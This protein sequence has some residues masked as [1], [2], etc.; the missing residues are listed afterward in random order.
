MSD[1]Q[2]ADVSQDNTEETSAADT[3][4]PEG[5]EESSETKEEESQPEGGESS[6]GE[7]EEAGDKP[8]EEGEA[9]G[10]KKEASE[11]IKYDL[12]MPKETLLNEGVV[13]E[14]VSMAKEQGLSNDQAQKFLDMQSDFLSEHNSLMEQ[15]HNEEVSSWGEQIKTDKELGG[16]NLGKNAELAKRVVSELVGDDFLHE[17]DESGYGNHP[18][19]FKLLVSVGKQMYADDLVLPGAQPN[20]PKSMADVFYPAT[21]ED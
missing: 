8:A 12:K 16:E 21:T 9:E 10:D 6:E 2:Q 17:L 15:K 13:D 3:L 4:Y 20:Q 18:K 7:S 11:E 1:Q 5:K 14:I 19:L